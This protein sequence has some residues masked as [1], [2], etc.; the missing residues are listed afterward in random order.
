MKLTSKKKSVKNK[1]FYSIILT[2]PKIIFLT[3]NSTMLK[4]EPKPSIWEKKSS[5]KFL[6]KPERTEYEL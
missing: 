2:H 4:D 3:D 5:D 6:T 1:E